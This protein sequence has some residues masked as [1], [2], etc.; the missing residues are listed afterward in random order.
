MQDRALPKSRA[1]YEQQYAEF[2]SFLR[3]KNAGTHISPRTVMAY[4]VYLQDE[5]KFAPSTLWSVYSMLKKMLQHNHSIDLD[6]IQYQP[7]RDFLGVALKAHVPAS[8]P[9]FDTEDLISFIRSSHQD[10]PEKLQLRILGLIAMI[11]A[12]RVSEAHNLLARNVQRV[13]NEYH[14]TTEATK[15][16]AG[17]RTF[18]ISDGEH[19]HLLDLYL[20]LRAA[21]ASRIPNFFVGISNQQYKNQPRGKQWFQ[22]AIRAIASEVG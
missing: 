3:Q 16:C 12:L 19:V 5:K 2:M 15:N 10:D 1:K 6:D 20:Q 11:G 21:T 18:V 13:G 17:G 4:F 7:L 8:A 22:A 9:S 14:I